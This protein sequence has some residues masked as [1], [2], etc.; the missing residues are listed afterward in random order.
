MGLT[1]DVG[2]A[3]P[4]LGALASVDRPRRL[5]AL[6]EKLQP[7]YSAVLPRNPGQAEFH[8]AVLSVL[9]SLG[10]VIAKHPGYA[11]ARLLERVC[12]PERHIIF[13]VV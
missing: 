11:A 13:R 10:P 12:E 1:T 7:L 6:D 8:Q 3:G 9:Q 2:P 4:T 5:P